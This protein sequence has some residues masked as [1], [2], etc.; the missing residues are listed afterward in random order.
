MMAI[1]VEK[2]KY[3]KEKYRILLRHW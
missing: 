3:C 2:C 1:Y